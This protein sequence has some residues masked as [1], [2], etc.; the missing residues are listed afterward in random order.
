ME[1]GEGVEMVGGWQGC[2]SVGLSVI[3]CCSVVVGS[4]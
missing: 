3:F 2:I 4:R 1:M